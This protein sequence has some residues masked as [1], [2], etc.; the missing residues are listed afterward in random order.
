L[1]P[2]GWL[3]FVIEIRAT[4]MRI[5]RNGQVARRCAG[6]KLGRHSTSVTAGGALNALGLYQN[7]AR[8]LIVPYR[9]SGTLERT[10]I[11]IMSMDSQGGEITP[12]RNSG[13]RYEQL[14]L[15]PRSSG[16]SV[17]K[18]NVYCRRNTVSTSPAKATVRKQHRRCERRRVRWFRIAH[19]S[20]ALHP[21][22]ALRVCP[23]NDRAP[24][25]GH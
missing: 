13:S 22:D 25:R 5:D 3:A 16:Q 24:F 9:Q 18:S 6:A 19:H 23:R 4:L 11:C 1:P 21:E 2:Q 20:R 12:P 14:Q 17:M 8:P 15:R 7:C 10:R